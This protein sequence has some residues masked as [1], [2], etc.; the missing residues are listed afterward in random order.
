MIPHFSDDDETG[1]TRG[2]P[3]IRIEVWSDVQCVWCYVGDARLRRAVEAFP[4]EVEIVHRSF[5]LQPGF[6]SEVDATEYLRENRGMDAA[7]QER[8]FSQ[9]K[10]VAAAE[11]LRYEPQS[12]RPT[13]SHLALEM[14]H[15]AQAQGVRRRMSDRLY[16]AYFVEGRHLGS[17]DA[18]VELAGDAGLDPERARAALTAGTYRAAVDLDAETGRALGARGVPFMVVDDRFAVPGALGTEE[19]TQLLTRVAAA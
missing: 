2:G 14:L 15:Y 12:I 9:M 7:E 10:A 11:G 18:L 5:E 1:K 13:N 3:A 6:P 4:G 17:V 19:L 8:V 16:R